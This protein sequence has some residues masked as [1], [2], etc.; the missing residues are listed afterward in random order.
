M[1]GVKVRCH[2]FLKWTSD[3]TDDN[4]YYKVSK[5]FSCNPHYSVILENQ[6]D[7][8]VWGNWGFVSPA[9]HHIG[10][11]S[12]SGHDI[13][14]GQASQAWKW[15]VIN[16]A[17]YEY[18]ND[19]DTENIT[20]PHKNLKI[21]SAKTDGDQWG[22]APMLR[23]IWGVGLDVNS[24]A[25]NVLSNILIIPASTVLMTVF[26]W[27]LPDV[28]IVSNPDVSTYKGVYSTTYHEL[29]HASHCK[30]VGSTYWARYAS[31]IMSHGFGY[32]DE[33][34][35]KD[36]GVCEVGES[37]AYA[38]ERIN[39]KDKFGGTYLSGYGQWFYG[40]IETLY[41]LMSNNFISRKELFDNI[42]SD[43]KTMDDLYNKLISVSDTTMQKTIEYVF[44]L[45]GVLSSQVQWRI[46]NSTMQSVYI[47]VTN[48]GIHSYYYL[49]HGDEVIIDACK[50]DTDESLMV[51]NIKIYFDGK[52][53]YLQDNGKV[54]VS[55]EFD[56]DNY[57]NW[58]NSTIKKNG[59]KYYV[60][61]Y[62][63]RD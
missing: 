17:A 56:I 16:N 47:D 3:Y 48:N 60:W 57:D 54:K 19:C 2:Y 20:K 13:N 53:C 36:S 62:E 31:Y 5:K 4:G 14:V 55:K 40:S 49:S 12:T 63:F 33:G 9:N 6:K 28:I 37:W 39:Y 24:V 42:T 51:E 27:A 22:S 25:A 46:L 21:W 52:L 1:K 58:T 15:L 43:V 32:G 38:V 7:F 11:K 50:E 61:K 26:K 44:T 41:Y 34:G 35:D 29:C 45:N 10:R 23:R 30:K 18:Y 59:K 8:V